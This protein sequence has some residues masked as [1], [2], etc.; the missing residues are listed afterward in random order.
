MAELF[1][2]YTSGTEF[3][4]GTLGS[5]ATGVSGLNPI[6]DRV[7]SITDTNAVIKPAVTTPITPIGAVIAWLK[8]FT[9]TPTLPDGYVECSG[10]TL[11]DA[12]SVYNG[13]VIPDLNGG[14]FLEGRTTTGSTGG[15]ATMAHTHPMRTG[16][17]NIPTTGGTAWG[18][19]SEQPDTFGA[20][21]T[22]NRPPFYTVVWIMRIK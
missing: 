16:R 19:N 5:N 14:V 4:A 10:Q 21:N 15:A 2:Q 12:D 1:S 18:Q 9:N 11:S 17:D 20:S 7:N 8:S 13:Q 6:V 22:E 3:S